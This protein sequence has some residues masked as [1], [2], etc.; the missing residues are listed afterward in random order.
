[1][2]ES[3]SLH[4]LPENNLRLYFLKIVKTALFTFDA[5]QTKILQNPVDSEFK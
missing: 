1:M 2:S 4:C 5:I 3:F